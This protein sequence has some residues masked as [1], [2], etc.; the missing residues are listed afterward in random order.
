[1]QGALL[2]ANLAQICCGRSMVESRAAPTGSLSAVAASYPYNLCCFSL[3]SQTS[4]LVLALM[5][6]ARHAAT[7][8]ATYCRA[9]AA[10]GLWRLYPIMS[11]VCSL[12]GPA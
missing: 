7:A 2:A 12:F 10:A 4:P 11:A 5:L 8:F 1:M 3:T 6:P 9:C